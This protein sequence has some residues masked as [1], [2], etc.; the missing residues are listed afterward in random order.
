MFTEHLLC[1]KRYDNIFYELTHSDL[2]PTHETH[3]VISSLI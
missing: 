2:T 3:I 1:A